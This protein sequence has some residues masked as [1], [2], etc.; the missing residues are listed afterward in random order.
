MRAARS[1]SRMPSAGPISQCGFGSKSNVGGVP[2]R[3]TSELSAADVPTGTLSC[4]R[5][6]SVSSSASR[7][8]FDRL[9]ASASCSRISRR[10]G[11]ARAKMSAA[12]AAFLLRARH[13]FTGR[14][15]IALEVLDERESAGAAR[16]RA[17]DSSASSTRRIAGRAIADALSTSGR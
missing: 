15:L 11:F 14:V 12:I 17:P 7:R 8:R 16:R 3:R 2:Q 10:A 4:G 6:G 9:R 5:F 13:R 1:K